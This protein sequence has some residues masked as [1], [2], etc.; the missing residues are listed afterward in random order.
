MTVAVGERPAW[1]SMGQRRH[2]VKKL[3]HFH[4]TREGHTWLPHGKAK[5]VLMLNFYWEEK[6]NSWRDSSWIPSADYHLSFEKWL[7][8]SFVVNP[9]L[10][11][12]W[13]AG[14]VILTWI[15]VALAK[16]VWKNL[17]NFCWWIYQLISN[18]GSSGAVVQRCPFQP[19]LLSGIFTAYQVDCFIVAKRGITTL[20]VCVY[21][22]SICI[23]CLTWATNPVSL[24]SF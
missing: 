22:E 14:I 17:T 2:A 6:T 23:S 15:M 19:Q 5:V 16:E 4:G 18:Y 21:R 13:S 7:Q 20:T 1:V 10:G 24:T 9:E 11:F 3:S 12:M 8:C